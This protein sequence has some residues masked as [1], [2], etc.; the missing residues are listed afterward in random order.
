MPHETSG[1]SLLLALSA[2][3]CTVYFGINTSKQALL[4]AKA[5]WKANPLFRS[6]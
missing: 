1:K 6:I 3:Y 4:Q 2:G 5:P